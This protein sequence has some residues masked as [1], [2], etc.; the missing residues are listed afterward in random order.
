MSTPRY[1][2]TVAVVN[3]NEDTVEMLRYALQSSGFNSIVTG[4]IHDFNRRGWRR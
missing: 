3:S 4:H 1:E 2:E